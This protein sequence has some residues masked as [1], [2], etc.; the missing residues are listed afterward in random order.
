MKGG[1]SRLVTEGYMNCRQCYFVVD[2]GA[3]KTV[4]D[5]KMFNKE[6]TRS[7]D[8]VPIL[9]TTP[10]SLLATLKFKHKAGA[11]DEF[12]MIFELLQIVK[13][14]SKQKFL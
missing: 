6:A 14:L 12:E 10:Q 4:I 2:T 11:I 7:L 1:N 13:Q 5:R 9:E 3:I 8:R